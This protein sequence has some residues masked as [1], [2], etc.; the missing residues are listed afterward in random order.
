LHLYA[1]KL[2]DAQVGRL[3]SEKGMKTKQVVSLKNLTK[4]IFK[5]RAAFMKAPLTPLRAG[6]IL[7]VENRC[8]NL[9]GH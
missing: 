5:G 8:T 6:F 4:V 3:Y 1:N 9:N 7:R 2:K